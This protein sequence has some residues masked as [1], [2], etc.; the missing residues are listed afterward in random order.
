MFNHL[1]HKVHKLIWEIMSFPHSI[2]GN[3]TT[4]G[5]VEWCYQT[6]AYA[7]EHDIEILEVGDSK[8]Y[9]SIFHFEDEQ[10]ALLFKLS[11]C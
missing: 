6:C 10:D 8:E 7:F 5:D 4:A 9:W 2:T 1:P 11:R 3:D